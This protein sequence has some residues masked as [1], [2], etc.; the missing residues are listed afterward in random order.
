MKVCVYIVGLA[1]AALLTFT[2]CSFSYVA[3]STTPPST[4]P[5]STTA[6]STTALSNAAAQYLEIVRA[7]EITR[8]SVVDIITSADSS[9]DLFENAELVGTAMA[10]DGFAH[11][12]L[13][14]A[15]VVSWPYELR[16]A[17]LDVQTA[18]THEAATARQIVLGYTSISSLTDGLEGMA[19]LYQD[20]LWAHIVMRGK[21]GL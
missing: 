9:E 2:A 18:L 19:E 7:L 11:D 12:A 17:A 6:P 20:H 1:T 3:P 14:A 15:V 8:C 13:M 21:L 5:P 4:T 16:E 10:W